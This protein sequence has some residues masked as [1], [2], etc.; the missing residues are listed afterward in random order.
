MDQRGSG[1]SPASR[2]A[3]QQ[4]STR[5]KN[6]SECRDVVLRE[7]DETG[8]GE[9]CKKN[10]VRLGV[11]SG[12]SGLQSAGVASIPEIRRG[13]G[14]LRGGFATWRQESFARRRLLA[15]VLRADLESVSLF[16]RHRVLGSRTKC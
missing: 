9:G 4:M 12:D 13:M 2:D 7:H 6:P 3:Y 5:Q 10:L 1:V 8:K 16:R 14:G 11:S 15:E